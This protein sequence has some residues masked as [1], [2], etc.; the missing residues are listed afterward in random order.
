M[1]KLGLT[2]SYVM[3]NTFLYGLKGQI[4]AEAKS[5]SSSASIKNW[6][7]QLLDMLKT[8]QT[9]AVIAFGTGAHQVVDLWPG[10]CSSP[11]HSIL[12]PRRCGASR[13]LEHLAPTDPAACDAGLGRDA[14][15]NA[16]RREHIQEGGP[17]KHPAAR[18]A[19]RS[20]EVD[21]DWRHG[22]ANLNDPDRVEVPR[23]R[24]K[25]GRQSTTGLNASWQELNSEVAEQFGGLVLLLRLWAVSA[26][27]PPTHF[28]VVEVLDGDDSMVRILGEGY[29]HVHYVGIDAPE[30]NHARF[31]LEL[32]GHEAV[33]A[34][35][36]C[37]WQVRWG[38]SS[39]RRRLRLRP[40]SRLRV[41]PPVDGSE[42]RR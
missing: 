41:G 18:S 11:S 28:R 39:I 23:R 35:R 3:V 25:P 4:D 2:N 36:R 30:I 26:R 7:N 13:E 31:G 24:R 6:R 19:F 33:Q 9:Q 22:L 38:S 14:G 34:N 5:I 21:G 27:R 1:R 29:V 17:R 42:V 20:V 8:G 15:Y 12:L 32:G 37:L 40:Y 16:L 10:A